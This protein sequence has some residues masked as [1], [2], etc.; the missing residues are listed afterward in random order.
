MENYENLSAAFKEMLE[1]TKNMRIRLKD[2]EETI[3]ENTVELSIKN[4][5][6]REMILEHNGISASIGYLNIEVK[7]TIIMLKI[8][9]YK[10]K[11]GKIAKNELVESNNSEKST[12]ISE[13]NDEYRDLGLQIDFI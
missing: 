4:E 11:I 10:Q 9:L 12:F 1:R 8:C 5:Q 7:R 2:L 13:H 6:Y 3:N